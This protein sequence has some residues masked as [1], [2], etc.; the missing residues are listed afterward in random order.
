MESL[1]QTVKK[2]GVEN[3]GAK[4]HGEW[5][6]DETLEQF[7]NRAI[8]VADLGAGQMVTV[9]TTNP[10]EVA[11]CMA[12]KGNRM[13]KFDRSGTMGAVLLVSPFD[14][15]ALTSE[16]MKSPDVV[17]KAIAEK[18]RGPI[19][20]YDGTPGE[21]VVPTVIEVL[22]TILTADSRSGYGGKL[23]QKTSSAPFPAGYKPW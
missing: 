7:Y 23:N 6:G 5:N 3:Y 21:M 19:K 22:P 9:E 12:V 13:D 20:R 8:T 11:L 2:V 16:I 18:N 15:K 17:Y 1:L 10:N 4:G 14:A